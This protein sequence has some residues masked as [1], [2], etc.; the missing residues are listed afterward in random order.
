[1]LIFG[2]KVI[3]ER[4]QKEALL[5]PFCQDFAVSNVIIHFS[6]Q[7]A[8]DASVKHGNHD[9]LSVL[10]KSCTTYQLSA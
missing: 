5:F 4:L 6:E 2:R 3:S 7:L 1:M 8:M 9:I 10:N